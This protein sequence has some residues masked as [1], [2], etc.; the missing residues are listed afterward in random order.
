MREGIGWFLLIL[1][2]TLIV[3]SLFPMKGVDVHAKN[4]ACLWGMLFAI[5]GFMIAFVG[6]E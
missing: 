3:R 1:G 4:A 6:W 2:C 5:A